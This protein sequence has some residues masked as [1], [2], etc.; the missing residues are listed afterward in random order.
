MSDKQVLRTLDPA[1][2]ATIVPGDPRLTVTQLCIGITRV[3][4]LKTD[5]FYYHYDVGIGV[6]NP[7]EEGMRVQLTI[8]KV[9]QD[10]YVVDKYPAWD[11]VA[12]GE[13]RR[14][15][16]NRLIRSEEELMSYTVA[17]IALGPT[18]VA[19][20][21]MTTWSG[22]TTPRRTIHDLFGLSDNPLYRPTFWQK[23]FPKY[24]LFALGII[25]LI[26][27]VAFLASCFERVMRQ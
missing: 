22:T 4:L 12:P 20:E 19:P 23:S 8:G 21:R 3:D 7:S 9:D 15:W 16:S 5:S 1:L 24:A 10:G 2:L 11:D 27:A 25:G 26:L 6:E 14:I 18:P 17:E 13:K